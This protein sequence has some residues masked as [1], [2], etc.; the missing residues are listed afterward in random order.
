[1]EDQEAL[2][3]TI[4]FVYTYSDDYKTLYVNG[5]HGGVTS[6]GE[7]SFDLFQ[8]RRRAIKA[9]IHK[10][11]KSGKL[12]KRIKVESEIEESLDEVAI[13]R[14]RKVGITM[15][16]DAAESIANW[17]LEKVK[18]IRETERKIQERTQDE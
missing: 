9:E 4:K 8:E 5:I 18:Q 12:G 15:T 7:V 1:M 10:V 3:K 14:E 16:S 6:Q 17:M 2:P 13:I 11:N